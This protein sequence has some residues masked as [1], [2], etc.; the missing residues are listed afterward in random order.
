M[1]LLDLQIKKNHWPIYSKEDDFL[2]DLSSYS[3]F[4]MKTRNCQCVMNNNSLQM[5]A[6][7]GT[8]FKPCSERI[9]AHIPLSTTQ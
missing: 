1:L 7:V 3:L 5:I 2:S 9:R 6:H 4:E 8:H